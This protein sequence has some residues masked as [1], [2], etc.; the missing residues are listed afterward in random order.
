MH[1][2]LPSLG[3]SQ[4]LPAV[5]KLFLLTPHYGLSKVPLCPSLLLRCSYNP[6]QIQIRHHMRPCISVVG[7]YRKRSDR[8]PST[9]AALQCKGSAISFESTQT[10]LEAYSFL[11][12]DRILTRATHT[13]SI[14][15]KGPHSRT[16][17]DP[18]VVAV[19]EGACH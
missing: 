10:L 11:V 5:G 3:A 8:F 2:Y 6:R 19:F 13:S 18:A 1:G 7:T 17:I 4:L 12:R 9:S 16:P 14:V 15:G